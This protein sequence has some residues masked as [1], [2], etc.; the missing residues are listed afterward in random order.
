MNIKSLLLTGGT[1]FFGKSLLRYLMKESDNGR[2]VPIVTIIS[3][4]PEIFCSSYP[5]FARLSWLTL[6]KGDITIPET[7]PSHIRFTHVLH[8][9]TDSTNGPMLKPL[10]R[11]N[12]I[13]DGTRNVLDLAL[14]AGATRF[15]LTSSGGV[16][17]PQP[18]GMERIP[19]E[20]N[21]M[22]D[23]LNPN[24]AYSVS[25]RTAEHLCS[26]YSDAYGID[27][28]VARCFAFIGQDLPLD[29]HFAIGNF[30]ADA[31]VGRQISIKG[32]GLP[33]RSYLDQSDLAI[34]LLTILEY[35]RSLRAY[36]VGSDEAI[37]I[38]ELANMVIE[39]INPK[40]SVRVLND[41]LCKENFR[42]RYVP[43]ILRAKTEL[44]LNV[45]VSL[46]DAIK[47]TAKA[48][49]GMIKE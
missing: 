1:G 24:H 11:Y 47:N 14:R 19:E 5:E 6:I 39:V 21:G 33:I 27:V 41:H 3:R 40:L 45:T 28:V 32:D 2:S 42:N 12:Q 10:Q 30:I 38:K 44:G 23:P 16:Y 49:Q 13:V 20:Y 7:L 43:D 25:K 29:A 34:W 8:A 9:A 31:I 48:V 26:L 35:G 15:L 36:N 4:N 22:P 37:S 18:E 17:G 46:Y